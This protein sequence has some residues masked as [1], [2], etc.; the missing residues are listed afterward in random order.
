MRRN[1]AAAFALVVIGC[2]A[3]LTLLVYFHNR[4]TLI[5]TVLREYRTVLATTALQVEQTLDTVKK[6]VLT[7]S[8]MP[9]VRGLMR[10]RRAGG[11]DTETQSTD[12]VWVE[13]FEQ[14]MVA[15]LSN[16]PDY[17]R[18]RFI[19]EHGREQVR[20]DSLDGTP[21]IVPSNALQN[22]AEHPYFTETMKLPPGGLYVS[23]L[24]L[25]REQG[26]IELPHRPAL[27]VATPVYDVFS[28]LNGIIV[29]NLHAASVTKKIL[30]R[31]Q[32]LEGQR[33]LVNQDGYFL[34]HPDTTK[35]FGFDL[36]HGYRL[37]QIHP[38]LIEKL[39]ATDAFIEIVDSDESPGAEA[40]VHGFHKIAYDTRDPRNYWAL[41]FEVSNSIALEPIRLQ[42]D[43]QLA[44]G[45]AIALLGA[46]TVFVWS[47]RITRP[48]KELTATANHIAGGHYDKRVELT[49]KRDE[50]HE[51]SAAFNQMMDALVNAEAERT[52]FVGNLKNAVTEANRNLS[53]GFNQM[54]NALVTAET[55]R[56]QFVV[57]L[58]NAVTE[59]NRNRAQLEA[60]FQTM[61]DG[62]AVF[63]GQG[64]VILVN[65]A[66]ARINGYASTDEMKRNL[67]Y[68][69]EIYELHEPDGSPVPVEQWPPS[70]CLRGET[71]RSWVLHGR[72]KDTGQEWVFRYSGA[73]VYDSDG[74]Q[75]LAAI[76]VRDI[77][78]YKRVEDQIRRLNAQLEKRVRERTADLEAAN[79]ELEAFSYSVSHDLR[80]PLRAIDGFSQAL[81]ED[82]ADRIDE[83]G[84]QYL[85]RVRAG[86]VRMA[87]LIDDMLQL[88]R[89]TRT[90]IQRQGV[91]LSA[92]AGSVLADLRSG[93]PD[94]CVE[95]AIQPGLE[96]EGD[97]K[98]LR[99]ALVNLLSNAWKFTGSEPGP[100]IEFA[101][102]D[103]QGGQTFYVRDNG[104]GFDMTYVDKLFGAF[105]RLHT[106]NEFPGTGIGLAI[107]QR[108]VHRHGGR[109][110]AES[111]VN[112]GATIYFTIPPTYPI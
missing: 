58:K 104:V 97:P 10:A 45:L 21:E 81:L 98:L 5:S 23:Q 59:A 57:N 25:N 12:E 94:R 47:G 96:A 49:G 14:T 67:V 79:K 33:Y 38:R 46:I 68:F 28:Q 108:I 90:E 84:R 44:L 70:K 6:D 71:I 1:I 17:W 74:R 105:Q 30:A 9:P 37:Q 50:I 7:L 31:P 16:N 77:T 64:E 56:A 22:N 62:I 8:G 88:S 54:V 101:A 34:A 19:D 80:A 43:W 42:R 36:N 65:E 92:L 4:E 51:L 106:E 3:L 39:R 2:V 91:N 75:I 72:R 20:V 29:I 13:R 93:K 66:L 24:D 52:Q 100:R 111:V 99:I 48:L 102:L 69:A 61:E 82:Y 60:I 55:E 110:W 15:L 41:V 85:R 32:G 63:D 112:Q 107:V 83:T 76:V 109:V 78:E 11:Y 95:I 40:H 35:T 89:V 103:N 18:V 53:A 27:R 87:S 26:R 73:P 86:S